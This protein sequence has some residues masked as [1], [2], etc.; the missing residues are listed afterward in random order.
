MPAGDTPDVQFHCEL[1]VAL[2]A[3]PAIQ[4][5]SSRAIL[6]PP[7]RDFLV[8]TATAEEIAVEL[9]SFTQGANDSA[10]MQ[11]SAEVRPSG[12][13]CI[14]GR[15]S[16]TPAETCHLGDAVGTYRLL[17]AVIARMGRFP[18]FNFLDR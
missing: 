9:C 1:A 11:W 17:E 18:S 15:Y 2:G 4:V 6:P 3:G 14:P 16:H 8:E 10:T 12:S 5:M 7:V 13:I